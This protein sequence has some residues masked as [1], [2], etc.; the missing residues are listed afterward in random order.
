[1]LIVD[2]L[3]SG[4]GTTTV[5]HGISLEVPAGAIVSIVGANGAG[6]STLLNT[7]SGLVKVRRGA[8]SLD[9]QSLAG[10][11]AERIVR[12]GMTLVPERRQLFDMMTVEE[13]LMLGAHSRRE[14]AEIAHDIGVQFELFPV[15][16]ERRRQLARSLSGG[17][18]QM[19]AIA[20]AR[21]SRPRLIMMDEPSLGLAPLL[22]Q[23]VFELIAQLRDTGTTILLVEQNAQAALTVSDFAHVM[24]TGRVRMSGA[25]RDLLADPRVREMY[26][27]GENE[28][29]DSLEA[30]IRRKANRSQSIQPASEN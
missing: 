18:Q 5:L 27:G 8:F 25:A 23:K 24:E 1:M 2:D 7:L 30:R 20:R 26:L 13:N 3:C 15:L 4:Y 11:G 14:H 16:K 29:P 19:L 21:M 10:L 6:K 17:E 12:Q 9:G 28:G 22:V